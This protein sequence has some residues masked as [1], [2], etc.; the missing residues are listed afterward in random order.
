MP[1]HYGGTFPLTSHHDVPTLWKGMRA[2]GADASTD[3]HR[4]IQYEEEL[5]SSMQT[6]G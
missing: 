4:A 5:S 2:R 6:A 1:C 3:C